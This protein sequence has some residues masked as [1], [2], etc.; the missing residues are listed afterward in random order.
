MIAQNYLKFYE[1]GGYLA[2][3]LKTKKK[4]ASQA[5]SFLLSQTAAGFVP[6]RLNNFF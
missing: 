1:N 4:T 2:M 3:V 5:A 6:D